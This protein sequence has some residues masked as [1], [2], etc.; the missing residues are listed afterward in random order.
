MAADGRESLGKALVKKGVIDEDLLQIVSQDHEATSMKFEEA[1]AQAVFVS[2]EMI[3]RAMAEK[4]GVRYIEVKHIEADPGVAGK[5]SPE[6]VSR[7][8]VLPFKEDEKG[9]HV[10]FGSLSFDTRTQVEKHVR[11]RFGKDT[12]A[13]CTRK[14]DLDVKIGQVYEELSHETKAEQRIKEAVLYENRAEAVNVAIPDLVEAFVNEAIAKGATDIHLA[15]DGLTF[16]IFLRREG[17]FAYRRSLPLSLYSKLSSAIKQKAGMDAGDRIHTQDGQFTHVFGTNV[18]NIRVSAIPTVNDGESVVLRILDQ[19]RVTFDLDALGFFRGDLELIKSVL[20]KPHGLILVTGP[21]GSGKT[22]T[23]YSIINYLRPHK[24]SILTIEDP[25]EY[26]LPF[27]RQV[28]V[29]TR[30]GRVPEKILRAFLRHDPDIILV[31]EIRDMETAEVTM[32]SAE[33]GHLVL[34]TLHT[35]NAP[36][37]L[38]RLRDLGI[39]D[40]SLCYSLRLVVAQ[41]LVK[42][43]CERCKEE[44]RLRGFEEKYVRDA[45]FDPAGPYYRGAGC[46]ACGGTGYKGLDIV[47]EVL[48]MDEEDYEKIR[49]CKTSAEV[50]EF[51]GEKGCFPMRHNGLIKAQEG[52]TAVNEVIRTCG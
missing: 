17:T 8:N 27:V 43:I 52:I 1:L 45:G 39:S 38:L 16:R 48:A 12:V 19:S 21:T 3:A 34:S 41:R 5:F 32:H 44:V 4:F 11:R 15:C 51:A 29:N 49:A 22:T 28:Q 18:V 36:S 33:T 35:N 31:G 26:R 24:H 14:Q 42:R 9:V 13:Y 46:E 10:V 7:W 23:L 50:F 20:G 47:Y 6:Q 30:A 2:E 37:A 25:V 40:I